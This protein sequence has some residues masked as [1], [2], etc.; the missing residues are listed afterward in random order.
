[1]CVSEYIFNYFI[2]TDNRPKR[3]TYDEFEITKQLLTLI[4]M[5]ICVMM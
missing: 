4:L 1:M 5:I 2:L 3:V